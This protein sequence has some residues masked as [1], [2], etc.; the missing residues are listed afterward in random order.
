MALVPRA[1]CA[2]K[3][4]AFSCKPVVLTPIKTAPN[5]PKLSFNEVEKCSTD[6]TINK[7]ISAGTIGECLSSD[8]PLIGNRDKARGALTKS[9]GRP[10][11]AS[12]A[13]VQ[14][15]GRLRPIAPRFCPPVAP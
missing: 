4:R 10:N 2:D 8:V 3:Y 7:Q 14:T 9:S 1:R 12:S 5:E 15:R 13:E 11:K 6:L